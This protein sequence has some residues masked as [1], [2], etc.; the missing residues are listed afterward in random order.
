MEYSAVQKENEQIQNKEP[1]FSKIHRILFISCIIFICAIGFVASDI[2]L[3]SLPAIADYYH[4]EAFWAQSTMTAFLIT[5]AVFQIFSGS[6]SDKFGRK[7]V[8]FLFMIIFILA[9][10]GCYASSTI[11][12]LIFFRVLQAIGACAGMSIGQ[13]IVADLFNS[14]EMGRVLSITIPLV[15]FSP[16]IAPV[17]GGH[18]EI[19]FNWQTNFLILALYGLI[20]IFMLL[21]PIIP[22]LQENNYSQKKSAF[23]IKVFIQVLLN[24]KFFGFA[25]FMMVSNASYFSF[26]AACPFLLKKFGYSPTAVGYAFCAASFP[27]MFASFMGRRLSLTKSSL[28]IIFLGLI[29]NVIGGTVLLIMYFINWPHILALMIPVFII[30]IGNGLLMPFSSANAISLFPKNAGMVTGTL[31][32]MQLTAA[33]IGTAVMGIIENGTLYPL[34]VFVLG[35]AFL[36]IIYFISVFKISSLK[37]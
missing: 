10:V 20:I 8:L 6:L 11:Y 27:Y 35:I 17:L 31:G 12:E 5:M 13:A 33:G 28:Q 14:K 3:P 16:A 37:N 26:V 24:K 15:A 21:S 34:G 36:S 32:S 2:Y 9:S 4:K 18:I 25:L 19:H 1:N 30:T 7:N 22:K 29:L 23:D